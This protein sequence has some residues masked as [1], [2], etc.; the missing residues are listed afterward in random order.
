MQGHVTANSH[1]LSSSFDPGFIVLISI[2]YHS[3]LVEN[4]NQPGRLLGH[5][6]PYPPKSLTATC[7]KKVPDIF[8]HCILRQNHLHKRRSAS[9]HHS[10]SHQWQKFDRGHRPIEMH[11]I[12]LSMAEGRTVSMPRRGRSKCH[13]CC[14]TI[15]RIRPNQY[16][17]I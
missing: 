9:T 10:T 1:A 11:L 3:L 7:T 2:R 15:I 13:R 5:S 8:N 16:R 14:P 12:M 17:M 6:Q 4:Q